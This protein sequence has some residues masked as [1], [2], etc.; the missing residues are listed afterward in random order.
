MADAEYIEPNQLV[1]NETY[2]IYDNYRMGAFVASEYNV[3]QLPIYTGVGNEG[4]PTFLVNIVG[5]GVVNKSFNPTHYKFK[6]IKMG[7][8]RNKKRRRTRRTRT[9]RTKRKKTHRK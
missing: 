1:P 9:R 5:R 8:D 7:G 6:S 4:N 3:R 2:K